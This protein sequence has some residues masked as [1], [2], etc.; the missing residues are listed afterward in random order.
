MHA[1][2]RVPIAVV[3]VFALTVLAFTQ[4]RTNIVIT[5]RGSREL[6]K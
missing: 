1:I 3:F 5:E 4:E 6:L 2:W